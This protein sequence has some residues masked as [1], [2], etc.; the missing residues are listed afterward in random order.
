MQRPLLFEG[1]AGA[2]KTFALIGEVLRISHATPD[3]TCRVLAL[4][5]M[6]G[7]RRRL[8][9]S[10]SQLKRS[11]SKVS[12][13]CLTFDGFAAQLLSRWRSLA[14]DLLEVEI[15]KD[16]DSEAFESIANAAAVLLRQEQVQQW[17]RRSFDVVLVDEAQDLAGAKLLIVEG[18]A[19]AIPLIAAGDEFQNLGDDTGEEGAVAWLRR[20]GTPVVLNGSQRTKDAQILRAAAALRKGEGVR[21]PSTIQVIA[22]VNATYAA[23]CIAR[24][25]V[26]VNCREVALLTP[27]GPVKASF[28]REVIERLGSGNLKLNGRPVR[29]FHFVWEIDSRSECARVE[30][31]FCLSDDARS[32]SIAALA[33]V[34]GDRYVC[35]VVDRLRRL[36]SLTGRS[37]VSGREVRTIVSQ[38][39]HYRRAH[40]IGHRYRRAMTIHQAKNQEFGMVVVLWPYA[41]YGTSDRQRRLLYN[42]ITRAKQHA[43]IIVQDPQSKRIE[44]PPFTTAIDVARAALTVRPPRSRTRRR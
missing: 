13:D 18:L 12:F 27:V 5:F 23:V 30:S 21:Y 42:A 3:G 26:T 17:V 35:D 43:V 14:R 28:S 44:A 37:E 33:K 29:P 41:V 22:T 38:V 16:H 15:R 10:L 32:H 1:E 39:V 7:S 11:E 36:Q 20:V 40:C 9:D 24:Q 8:H 31:V 6:H 2:G 25:I 34:C 19:N 4:T